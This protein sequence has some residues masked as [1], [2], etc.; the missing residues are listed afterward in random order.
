MQVGEKGKSFTFTGKFQR[1]VGGLC[2]AT[3]Y[4]QKETWSKWAA[5]YG[6]GEDALPT[7]MVDLMGDKVP[8][9]EVIFDRSMISRII[10]A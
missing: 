4:V 2:P 6:W 8:L 1:S 10:W 5:H 3:A 9:H 7:D